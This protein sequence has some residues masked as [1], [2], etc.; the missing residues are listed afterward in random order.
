VVKKM[1]YR[2]TMSSHR[3]DTI[4]SKLGTTSLAS[5]LSMFRRAGR[6]VKRQLYMFIAG[7]EH[8]EDLDISRRHR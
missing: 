1:S 5:P 8:D 2:Q 4:G 6:K 3:M 7:E